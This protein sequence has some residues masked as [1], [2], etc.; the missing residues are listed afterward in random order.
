MTSLSFSM[1][2]PRVSLGPGRSQSLP[3]S[4]ERNSSDW[5]RAWVWDFQTSVPEPKAATEQAM[6]ARKQL[7]WGRCPNACGLWLE[8]GVEPA[9]GRGLWPAW[10]CPLC[11][12]RILR[13]AKGAKTGDG[14]AV[15]SHHVVMLDSEAPAD[16][17]EAGQGDPLG[18]E[19]V[20]RSRGGNGARRP[21]FVPTGLDRGPY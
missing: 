9:S 8:R 13:E 2:G 15:S 12:F 1:R 5:D 3:C 18:G 17:G 14:D 4:P 16:E 10:S 6:K 20:G 7:F 21:T 19:A 11:K